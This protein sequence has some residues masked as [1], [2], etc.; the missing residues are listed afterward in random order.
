MKH[1][2]FLMLLTT[3][4]FVN[5]LAQTVIYHDRLFVATGE[6]GA[7]SE[8]DAILRFEKAEELNSDSTNQQYIPN[9]TVPI[10]SCADSNGI[11][12]KFGHGFY[13]NDTTDELY[14]ACLFTSPYNVLTE[15]TDSAWG[16]IA[17]FDDASQMAN[18][19]HIPA[20]HLFGDSTGILQ[21]HGCWLDR[22]RD[23]LYVANTFGD[24]ILV[25]HN[26]SKANGNIA[27]DRIIYHDSIGN[28]VYIFIDE[29]HDIMFVGA[30][31]DFQNPWER[32]SVS[33][34]PQASTINGN[35]Q[36]IIRIVGD[37]TRL[38]L[39]NRTT[40]NVWYN[41]YSNM[42]AV[43]HHISELLFFDMAKF[44]YPA[45]Q[46]PP[47]NYN[48]SPAKVCLLNEKADSS[49]YDDWS[50]Y[51]F[52]WNIE[53]DI[54]YCSM[55]YTPMHGGPPPGSP[56]QKMIV[57]SGISDT[58]V[59]G[60]INPDRTIY[61]ASGDTFWPPQPIWVHKV[62]ETITTIENSNLNIA[63]LQVLPNPAIDDIS[64][65]FLS[66]EVQSI[67]VRVINGLGQQLYK[68][69]LRSFNGKFEKDIP[70]NTVKAGVYIVQIITSK[71]TIEKQIVKVDK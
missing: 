69:N 3:G 70:F 28:P 8:W 14:V 60:W 11:N 30:L 61:W 32:P 44:N 46:G 40:H 21:P 48:V 25:F 12:L 37:S 36:P 55:G 64:V 10:Y 57:I 29:E 23:M 34:F 65:Q 56:N 54:M 66:T 42:V 24:N 20:R 51:G 33:I 17:I 31:P 22:S 43:G 9:A 45:I 15:N 50:L 67:T 52:H 7:H 26:A 38:G 6:Y 63:D 49:D 58:T 59:S 13:Y 47:Q 4:I 68:E 41:K 18:G 1:I 62:A 19:S 16:S 5:N 39:H 71:G 35:L 27:P 2:L 53:D